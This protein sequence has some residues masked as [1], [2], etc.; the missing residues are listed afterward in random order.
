MNVRAT[1]ALSGVLMII[2]ALACL[3]LGGWAFRLLAIAAALAMAGEWFRL[4]R[5]MAPGLKLFGL[6]YVL[7]PLIGLWFAPMAF[8]S[9]LA[10]LLSV[11]LRDTLAP[12]LFSLTLWVLH[13]FLRV[14]PNFWLWMLSLPGLTAPEMRP[15]LLVAAAGLVFFAVVMLARSETQGTI[16]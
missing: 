1:R 7:L 6:P 12:M 5:T 4:T 13:L 8:L 9:A 14:Q 10:F 15:L 11:V 2:V 3:W 16:L